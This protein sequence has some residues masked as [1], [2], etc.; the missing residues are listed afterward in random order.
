MQPSFIAALT[1]EPDRQ[2]ASV[3]LGAQFLQ[4]SPAERQAVIDGWSFGV[5]WPYPDPARLACRKGEASTPLERIEASLVLDALERAWRSP[6][7]YLVALAVTHRAAELANLD[8]VD[9]FQRVASAL[10][11]EA[12]E[13]LL[14]FIRRAPADRSPQAFLLE[15]RTNADGEVEV[16]PNWHA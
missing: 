4:A 12:A 1:T 14:A 8:P 5:S 2:Q 16:Q 3:A 10:P 9:V 13:P 11:R 7:E 15:E 6:R